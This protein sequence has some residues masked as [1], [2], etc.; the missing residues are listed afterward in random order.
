MLKTCPR[1]VAATGNMLKPRVLFVMR[2][3]RM[4]HQ[5]E[6]EEHDSVDKKHACDAS[7]VR[8]TCHAQSGGQRG[9]RN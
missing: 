5:G 3:C 4:Q 6:D 9:K 2:E 8:M 1:R 7:S